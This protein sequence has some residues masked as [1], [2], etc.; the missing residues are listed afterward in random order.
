MASNITYPDKSCLWYIE[1]DVLGIFSNVDSSGNA[2]TSSRK[3]WKAISESI[4]G[5]ILLHYWAEPDGIS[6]INDVLDIDNTLHSAVVHY[7]KCALYMDKAGAGGGEEGATAM[8]LSRE[9][10][11]LFDR[12]VRKYGQLKNSKTGGFRSLVVPDL[13]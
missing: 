3:G 8:S 6:S 11:R 7:V 2:R 1:G 4:S 13:R 5:G 9:H 12:D 10:R